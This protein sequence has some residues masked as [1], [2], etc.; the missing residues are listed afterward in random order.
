MWA[1]VCNQ[2]MTVCNDFSGQFVKINP[3]HAQKMPSMATT[4]FFGFVSKLTSVL[5]LSA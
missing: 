2:G 3:F 1:H 5:V 4:H